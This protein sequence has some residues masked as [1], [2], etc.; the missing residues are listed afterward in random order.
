MKSSN[1]YSSW[2]FSA[3]IIFVFFTVR[4]QSQKPGLQLISNQK[5]EAEGVV[6]DELGNVFTFGKNLIEQRNTK[7]KVLQTNS[8]KGFGN[9]TSFDVS[10]PL[11]PQVFFKNQ[12]QLV[13]LDNRLAKRGDNVALDFLGYSQISASC[14]SYNNGFWIYDMSNYELVRFNEQTNVT[15]QT[16]NLLQITG[17]NL[18]ADQ[19]LETNKRLYIKDQEIGIFVFDIYGTYYKHL[20]LKNCKTIAGYANRVFILQHEKITVLN[21]KNNTSSISLPH[22]DYIDIAVYDDYLFLLGSDQLDIY[23][24]KL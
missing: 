7:G 14:A 11:K 6:V 3:L 4:A 9:I 15:N 12:L 18:Q 17:K 1:S 13:F 2:L 8:I 20:P 22:T 5:V 24:V 16:P 19:L 10:N 23:Q 21:S